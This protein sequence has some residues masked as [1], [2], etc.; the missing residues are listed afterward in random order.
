[1][2]VPPLFRRP[3]PDRHKLLT[4]LPGHLQRLQSASE[5]HSGDACSAPAHV[6]STNGV[7]HHDVKCNSSGIA[8]CKRQTLKLAWPGVKL[9]AGRYKQAG[10]Q[11]N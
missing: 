1:M 5:V 11:A 6:D 8:D 7:M 10:E 4:A 3:L 2:G 9:V